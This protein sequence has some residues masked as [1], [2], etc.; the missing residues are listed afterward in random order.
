MKKIIALVLTVVM[1]CCFSVTAFAADS[2]TATEKVTVTIR[3][4]NSSVKMD[5]AH[6]LG[7]GDEVI[8]KADETEFGTFKSW[9]VYKT[10]ADSKAVEAVKGVDYEIVAGSL[11]D[12]ELT[13][14]LITSV[15]VCANYGDVVTDPLSN[16]KVDGSASAPQT[17]DMT[18]VYA[19]VIMLA[20]A[21][22]TLGVKKVY[23]K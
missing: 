4:A 23:S 2:P 16:S 13:I 9:S 12:K 14:K 3:K 5:V 15:V 6:T 22:F 7:K 20:A 10:T 21:A 18:A 1:I 19:V 8:V 17:G 11:N